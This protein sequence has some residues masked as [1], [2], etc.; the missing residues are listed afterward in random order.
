MHSLSAM[1]T[2]SPWALVFKASLSTFI[3]LET[4]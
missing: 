1:M 3:P 4:W 2:F